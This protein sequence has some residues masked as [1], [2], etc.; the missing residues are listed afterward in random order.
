MDAY[1]VYI[2]K[3]ITSYTT[4]EHVPATWQVGHSLTSIYSLSCFL[5]CITGFIIMN[6]TSTYPEYFEIEEAL[7]WIWQGIIAFVSDSYYLG[8][9]SISHPIDRISALIVTFLLMRKYLTIS[10]IICCYPHYNIICENDNYSNL[11]N[12]ELIIGLF[13][14]FFCLYNSLI[15][16][17]INNKKRYFMFHTLWHTGFPLTTLGFHIILLNYEI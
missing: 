3:I 6:L 17:R 8:R 1:K 4:Y 15:G 16:Y 2:S 5:Y 11:L 9:N 12:I 14:S 7:I 10:G 13:Y